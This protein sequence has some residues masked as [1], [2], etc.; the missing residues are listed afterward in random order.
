MVSRQRAAVPPA[1][2]FGSK[3]TQTRPLLVG[4][5]CVN[6]EPKALAG[7]TAARCRLTLA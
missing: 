5:V 6:F 7:G 2:A 1:S 3:L 4:R